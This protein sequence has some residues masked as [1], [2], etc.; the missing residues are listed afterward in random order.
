[1]SKII[2]IFVVACVLQMFFVCLLA[3]L[4]QISWYE[5]N[6]IDVWVDSVYIKITIFVVLC[7]VSLL[8]VSIVER[9]KSIRPMKFFILLINNG[10]WFVV[11][12]LAMG[13]GMQFYQYIDV[14]HSGM[15]EAMTQFVLRDENTKR[16]VGE[17]ISIDYKFWT[18]LKN[19]RSVY[20]VSDKGEFYIPVTLFK[21]EAGTWYGTSASV[22][23]V[24]PLF[25]HAASNN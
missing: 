1:M 7:L 8:F 18:G 23:S 19:G 6:F 17:I 11:L 21:D 9:G 25:K 22:F 14:K 13:F 4:Y 20:V 16:M 2:K 5:Y 3:A 10:G 24:K 15:D 12:V